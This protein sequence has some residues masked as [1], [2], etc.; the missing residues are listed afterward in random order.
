MEDTEEPITLTALYA[1]G[2][3]TG[4]EAPDGPV[5]YAFLDTALA[6]LGITTEDALLSEIEAEPL[7]EEKPLA[8]LG[9]RGDDG[10][11]AIIIYRSLFPVRW[12]RRELDED[13]PRVT[14]SFKTR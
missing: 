6:D 8:I 4:V 14:A 2:V 12:E 5:R 13:D 9:G 11:G 3:L 10:R 1:L 7:S